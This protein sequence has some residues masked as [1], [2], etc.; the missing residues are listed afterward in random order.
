[1]KPIDPD[2]LLRFPIPSV[3]QTLTARD[4]AFYALSIGMGEYPLDDGRLDY[5]DPLRGPVVM[6]AMVLVMAHP[7][8]WV[9]HPDSG[10]D[11][12]AV[13]HASQ[14][15]RIVGAL[16]SE[17]EIESRSR[18]T[19]LQ[20]K[21]PGKA[22]LFQT[23]T[24]LSDR[25]GRTFAVLER[26]SFVRGGGGFGGENAKSEPMPEPP[27]V[28][29]DIVVDLPTS[30][31]QA[32]FYRLNGDLNP[33]HIDPAIAAR[34]GFASPILHGL[35]TMGIA[36]H[37]LLKALAD[38]RPGGLT[39]MS[40]RFAGPIHPGETVRTEIWKDGRFRVLAAERGAVIADQGRA[41]IAHPSYG[42]LAESGS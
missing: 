12:E 15:F 36:A 41:D 19:S 25:E 30:R 42:L 32:I 38:Y 11:P 4:I 34:A 1:M 10:V 28:P 33:L 21:G 26:T 18:V 40:M 5:V 9:A 14:G 35:C 8:F 3:R 22:A 37:A 2:K 20:D 24:E 13:L 7:G 29:A 31:E 6:P 17:G 39:A 16:P 27:G 23:L